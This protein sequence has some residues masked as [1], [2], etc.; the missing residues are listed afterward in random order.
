MADAEY[1]L[2]L[3]NSRQQAEGGGLASAVSEAGLGNFSLQ[4]K[5]RV[6]ILIH[7]F[8][9]DEPGG[10]A[11]YQ[12][13]C[14]N[15]IAI[16]GFPAPLNG[17]VGFLWPGD[18][19]SPLSP[20][21][22]PFQVPK[23]EATG[24]LL[25]DYLAVFSGPASMPLEIVLIAHSLG[26]RVALECVKAFPTSVAAKRGSAV[27]KAICLMAA[28]V[29][30]GLEHPQRDS[31]VPSDRW[32]FPT[33]VALPDRLV[34]HSRADDVLHYAFPPGELLAGEGLA[35]AVGRTGGPAGVWNGGKDMTSL[36]YGHGSYW[37]GTE[38]AAQI[39]GLLGMASPNDLVDALLPTRSLPPSRTLPENA[40]SE[41]ILKTRSIGFGG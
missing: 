38:S 28:A 32:L 21:A 23:A 9:V 35:T 31:D 2:P 14:Q 39:S 24:K 36:Q 26:C 19:N 4:G 41:R 33:S 1:D 16:W 17:M 8:N 37:V 18:V 29:P 13:L 11:A 40:I 20:L 30:E 25:A 15:L 7:G 22:Y 10:K 3:L 6:V 5:C 27:I 34:L 12:H